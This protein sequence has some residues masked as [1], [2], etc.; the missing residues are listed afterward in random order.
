MA[1]IS[2]LNSLLVVGGGVGLWWLRP[3]ARDDQWWF[4]PLMTKTGAQGLPQSLRFTPDGRF[5][6]VSCR[7]GSLPPGGGRVAQRE[8]EVQVWDVRARARQS[9]LPYQEFYGPP[10]LY[11]RPEMEFS[12]NG[13]TLH[14]TGSLFKLHWNYL[15]GLKGKSTHHWKPLPDELRLDKKEALS[16]QVL[17]ED[18][19]CF[20]AIVHPVKG[21][22][23]LRIWHRANVD[24]WWQVGAGI[25]LTIFGEGEITSLT[26]SRDDGLLAA[27]NGTG[28]VEV[29]D[30]RT[31]KGKAHLETGR[32]IN[33]IAFSPD[34][35]VLLTSGSG[36]SL[37][38]PSGGEL[39]FW[40]V[41][42]GRLLRRD[43]VRERLRAATYSPKGDWVA[44]IEG[45]STVLL[46]R[47]PAIDPA[48]PTRTSNGRI[49]GSPGP[50]GTGSATATR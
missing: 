50:K 14:V 12:P 47:P 39:G 41:P 21:A 3:Q 37:G 7:S 35:R 11:G 20:A 33:G 2:P 48:V 15:T 22:A 42:N 19:R 9:A 6:A 1:R 25:P 24:A 38:Q 28:N 23:Y 43:L 5:L 40:D 29:L 45:D 31:A 44:A 34:G 32:A 18:E 17:S 13:Y 30:I 49:G 4:S 8:R 36:G 16:N 10:R 27:V 46:Q 26:I